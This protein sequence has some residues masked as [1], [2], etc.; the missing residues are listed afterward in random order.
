MTVE[1]FTIVN[2]Y[3]SLI[4]SLY[5]L[6]QL[7]THPFDFVIIFKSAFVS[8]EISVSKLSPVT[9]FSIELVSLS[10]MKSKPVSC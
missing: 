10:T 2:L 6:R 3:T 1:L 5:S 8:I 9:I 7:K 4:G